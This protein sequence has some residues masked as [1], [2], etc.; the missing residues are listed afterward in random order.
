MTS[1]VNLEEDLAIKA[2]SQNKAHLSCE[3]LK[4]KSSR[5]Y[6]HQET[7]AHWEMKYWKHFK[8]LIQLCKAFCPYVPL[9]QYLSDCTS[10]LGVGLTLSA[11]AFYLTARGTLTTIVSSS[12]LAA[13]RA[14]C[15]L[16]TLIHF[17]RKRDRGAVRKLVRLQ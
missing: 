17:S 5:A 4:A 2:G 3:D 13:L 11:L 8:S 15:L 10:T 6:L 14:D 16:L 7:N 9:H 1:A 12:A